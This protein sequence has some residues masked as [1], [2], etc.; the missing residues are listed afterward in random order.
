[1]STTPE[2]VSGQKNSNACGGAQGTAMARHAL[3]N[4]TSHQLLGRGAV[5]C[6]S[7]A[8]SATQVVRH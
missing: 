5:D 7:N 8:I 1:M 3:P 4:R 2:R 6:S